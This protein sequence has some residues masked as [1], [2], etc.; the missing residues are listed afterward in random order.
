MLLVDHDQPQPGELD[1]LLHDRLRAD[2]QIELAGRDLARA[3][4]DARPR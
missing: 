4:R 2:H 3:S 1:V